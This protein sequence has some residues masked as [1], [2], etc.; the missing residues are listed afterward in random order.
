M[1]VMMMVVAM[2]LV[3]L[4]GAITLLLEPAF[5]SQLLSGLV[6]V[7]LVVLATVVNTTF[8]LGTR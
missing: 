7:V 4:Q 8:V 5:P 2:I 1:L 3:V 6:S